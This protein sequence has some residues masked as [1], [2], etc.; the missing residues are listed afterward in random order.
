M[1]EERLTARSPGKL[2]KKPKA[3]VGR[4]ACGNAEC[5][6]ILSAYNR[7]KYCWRHQPRK[8]PRL[9]GSPR[10]TTVHE[11]GCVDC[12]DT[13]GDVDDET[14]EIWLGA[15]LHYRIGFRANTLCSLPCQP[16]EQDSAELVT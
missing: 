12:M 5:I 13:L 3:L 14:T 2:G 4:R 7:E 1:K 8:I 10:E 15:T 16:G 11:M 9:R 6:T